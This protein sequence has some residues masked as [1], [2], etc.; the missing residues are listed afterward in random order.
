MIR[1]DMHVPSSNTALVIGNRLTPNGNDG[2]LWFVAAMALVVVLAIPF[3]LVDVPPVLDYPNHLA[4]YFVLAHPDDAILSQMY[5]PHWTILPNLGMDAIGAAMLR[6][7]DVHVG[8]RILLALSLFAP[9][10]GVAVYNRVVFGRHSYWSL[11]SGLTAYNGAF[12]LGFMN[13]LL[14]LGLAFMGGAAWIALSRRKWVLGRI[15]IRSGI[16]FLLSHL[17]RVSFCVVDWRRRSRPPVGTSKLRRAHAARRRVRR[18][19]TRRGHKSRDSALF[20]EPSRPGDRI[21]W[22]MARPRQIVDDLRAIHDSK[23]RT[24]P[25]DRRRGC[26]ASDPDPPL[27]PTRPGHAARFRRT[28][29]RVCGRTLNR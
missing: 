5:A 3:F 11:A 8:G 15:A 28:R 2:R 23:R 1:A 26:L 9:V 6:M 25:D 16:D 4:R 21:G 14:S 7:T 20:F 18:W 27:R 24:D 17:R 29:V 12:F 22:R 19:Y 13:F 10:I